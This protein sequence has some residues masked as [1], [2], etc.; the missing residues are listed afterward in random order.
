MDLAQVRHV[1]APA[2]TLNATR[3]AEA[4]PWA[5]TPVCAQAMPGGVAPLSGFK[6]RGRAHLGCRSRSG[7][8]RSATPQWQT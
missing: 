6:D 7:W 8:D 3:A 1:P 4:T 5:G 2:R